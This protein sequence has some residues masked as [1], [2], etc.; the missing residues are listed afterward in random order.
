MKLECHPS[1]FAADPEGSQL[2][3]SINQ[4]LPPEVR[5][6][7]RS[8]STTLHAESYDSAVY[9]FL[10][11]DSRSTMLFLSFSCCRIFSSNKTV[12]TTMVAAY[13]YGCSACS[14]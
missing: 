10:R 5:L 3:S 13:R 11:V 9:R 6:Q 1:S 7:H 8:C 14:V 2:A 4:H 12:P